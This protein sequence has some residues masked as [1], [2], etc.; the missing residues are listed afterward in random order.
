[1]FNTHPVLK[2]VPM[3]NTSPPKPTHT[4]PTAPAKPDSTPIP[5]PGTTH[6][7][8]PEELAQERL[9]MKKAAEEYAEKMRQ[10]KWLD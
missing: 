3:S 5:N 9:M 4:T 2:A 6:E 8:T 1:M 7:F 10:R